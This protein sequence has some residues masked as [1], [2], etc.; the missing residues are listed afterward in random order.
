MRKFVLKKNGM[1]LHFE[2]GGIV[3]F[4]NINPDALCAFDSKTEAQEVIND[5]GLTNTIIAE[6]FFSETFFE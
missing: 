2:L 6:E 5:F 1:F 3:A 4:H